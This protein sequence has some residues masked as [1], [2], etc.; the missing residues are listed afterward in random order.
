MALEPYFGEGWGG[1]GDYRA[2]F[3][4]TA[5]GAYNFKDAPLA[6]SRPRLHHQKKKAKTAI[7]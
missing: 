6:G 3:I 4:Q 1:A 2:F 7:R 5:L